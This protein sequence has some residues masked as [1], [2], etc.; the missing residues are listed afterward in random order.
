MAIVLRFFD[1]HGIIQE[2]FLDLVHVRDT[3]ALTLKT[4]IWNQLLQYQFDVSKIR[5]QGYDGA[6]NMSGEWNGLQELV[7][8]GSSK[9]H[10]ELQKTKAKEIKDLIELGEIKMGK[11]L[12]QVGTLRKAGDRRWGSHYQSD[13][14]STT[15]TQR[16]DVDAGYVNLKS[17]D[18]VFILHLIKKVMGRTKILS[19]SLQKK[20]Q[21]LLNA[22]ELVKATKDYLNDFG[23]NKWDSF[24]T[25]VTFFCNKHQVDMPDMNAPYTSTRYRPRKKDNQVTFE[26]YYREDHFKATVDKQLYEL[27]ARFNYQTMEKSIAYLCKS[28]AK[29][30]LRDEHYF[31]DRVVRL[32]L[33]LPVSTATTQRGFSAMKIFKN[34]LRNN[35]SDDYLTN[36]LAIH[37]EKELVECFDSTSVIDEFKELKGRRTEL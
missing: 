11:R 5:G 34:R 25:D 8:Y 21:D 32:I 37:I 26:H 3:L 35:M 19:Y 22:I 31:L 9:F 23:N 18:F 27:N 20:S 4:H 10:D 33:T 17:F 12:N 24:L 16:A 13:E 2:R 29:T 15:F 14:P 28:L 7:L 1:A 36:N 6:S 30:Q